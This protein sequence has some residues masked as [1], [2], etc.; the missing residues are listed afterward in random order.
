MT[1]GRSRN[2]E[3]TIVDSC[4]AQT[5]SHSQVNSLALILAM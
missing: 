2:L 4:L 3:F 1:N 5:K